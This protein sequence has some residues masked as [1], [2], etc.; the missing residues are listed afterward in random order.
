MPITALPQDWVSTKIAEMQRRLDDLSRAVGKPSDQVRDIN[1]NVIHMPGAGNPVIAGRTHDVGISFFSGT[2]TVTDELGRGTRPLT[3]SNFNGPV[4]GDTTGIHHGDVGT[5]TELHN[6]YGDLH[7]N[8]YGF[9]YGPVGDGT[10]QNQINCLNIFHTGSYGRCFGEVG[11]AGGPFFTTYG[12][13]GNGTNFF[14]LFGTVHAP[15]ERGLKMMERP[16]EDVGE[17]IDA[18]PSSRWRWEPSLQLD[19]G[20]DHAGP[21]VDDVDEIAPWLVR[22]SSDPGSAR[23]LQDRDLIGVLWAAL[24]E[25][26]QRTAALEQRI[27]RLESIT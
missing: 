2:A 19:D 7:G 9:H 14:Q 22:R 16:I 10:T 20:Y 13:V 12:D 1:D 4:T 23:M 21:M 5:P 18:V 3:A 17:I 24:R 26:R 15:S 27:A 6:H 25:E 8:A 11:Q